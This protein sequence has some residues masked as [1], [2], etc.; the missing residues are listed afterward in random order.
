MLFINN[1]YDIYKYHNRAFI[2]NAAGNGI[3]SPEIDRG[4]ELGLGGEE[5]AESGAFSGRGFHLDGALVA[6]HDAEDG[7]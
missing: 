3:G 5:H 6:A 2:A 4:R 1:I 7:R